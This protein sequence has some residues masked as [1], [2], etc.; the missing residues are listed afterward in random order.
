MKMKVLYL[1]SANLDVE[2]WDEHE[3]SEDGGLAIGMLC[4]MAAWMT[5]KST[6]MILIRRC[7][8]LV[9]GANS[10]GSRMEDG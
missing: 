10:L 3:L 8:W 4:K 5:L 9:M 6:M 1:D 7:M 2:V